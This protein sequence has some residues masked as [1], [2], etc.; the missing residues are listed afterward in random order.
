MAKET[1]TH[2]GCLNGALEDFYPQKKAE[3]NKLKRL[4]FTLT[5]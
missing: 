3:Q 1:Y 5:L 4:T 2:F